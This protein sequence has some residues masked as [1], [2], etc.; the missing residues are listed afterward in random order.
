MLR[1]S[2]SVAKAVALAAASRSP[3]FVSIRGKI[4]ASTSNTSATPRWRSLLSTWPQKLPKTPLVRSLVGVVV[5]ARSRLAGR[6]APED[7][8]G[9]EHQHQH[10]DREDDHVGP[11]HLE[12]LAAERFNEPDQDA[13]QHGAGDVADPAQHRR[14]E[15][16][17]ACRIADDEAGVV[18]VE[19]ED[20]AGGARER[21]AQEERRHDHAVDIDAHHAGGLLILR[22]RLHGLAHL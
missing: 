8:R 14:R 9:T 6:E 13:A 19:T 1:P 22:G 12:V 16:S 21:G 18:V 7:T 2:A 5:M 10:Q 11:A 4:S 3:S 20:H 17:E 15:G